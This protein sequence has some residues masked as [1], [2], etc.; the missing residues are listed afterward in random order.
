MSRQI[1]ELL[2]TWK[3]DPQDGESLRSYGKVTLRFG[4]DGSLLYTVHQAEKDQ[5]MRLTF[6]LESGF[7]VTDQPSH[8]QPERTAY[9][10]TSDGK[11]V[12]TFGGRR[13]SYTRVA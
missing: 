10:L 12:L 4:S 3:S 8:P 6:R 7:I 1:N 13:V 11:L 2:G 5:V 9:E